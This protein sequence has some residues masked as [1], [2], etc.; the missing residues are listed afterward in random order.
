MTEYSPTDKA[1]LV[2]GIFTRI[3]FRYDLMNR[4]MSVGQDRAWRRA[5]VRLANVPEQGRLLDLGCGTGD[6]AAE[7]LRQ[8]PGRHVLAMDFTPAMLEVGRRRACAVRDWT[9]G[10]ALRLPLPDGTFDAVISA[11]LLRNVA[12]L[13]QSLKEQRRV[14]KPGGRVV[15]L[16][17]TQPG[18]SIFTPLVR[19]YLHRFIPLM[20]RAIIGQAEAYA[21]LPDSMEKFVRAEDLAA[22]MISVGF[23]AVTFRRLNFGTM[24][25]H[26]AV[27]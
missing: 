10:D 20:G 6:M 19:V 15:I 24:A 8:Y 26:W 23:H 1:R 2:R 18:S 7:A 12:D 11:F 25:I 3:A 4:I 17:A 27:K 14:L 21:Y 16:D 22:R 13:Q 9:A 5:S